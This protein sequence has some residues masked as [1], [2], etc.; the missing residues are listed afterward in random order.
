M[1]KI[2][3]SKRRGLKREGTGLN[4]RKSEK[5]L[6]NPCR[7]RKYGKRDKVVLVGLSSV[8]VES[9]NHDILEV[10]RLCQE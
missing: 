3:R 10:L 9:G 7:E 1:C 4:V 5:L 8:E 2:K 6:W